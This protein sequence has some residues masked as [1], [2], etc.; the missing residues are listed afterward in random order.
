MAVHSRRAGFTLVEIL[1]VLVIVGLVSG[2]LLQALQQI[3]KLQGRFGLQL[4]QSQQ[5]AMYTDWFRQVVQGLQTD[6]RDGKNK[7]KGTETR[8]QGVST[9]PLSTAYGAPTDV[10]LELR[11][12]RAENL[13]RLQYIADGREMA[14]FSWRGPRA[15]RFVY[16]DQKGERHEQWPPEF[17]DWPQLPSVILLQSQ[18]DGQPRVLSGVPRG[19]LEPK[20]RP[21]NPAGIPAQ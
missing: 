6:F 4:A 13:T 2:I 1:V 12:D 20:Q 19:A 18:Q 10:A 3:Y 15:G 8:L 16:I 17:G 14:L 7:F 9:S 11:Y 21:F 5:G